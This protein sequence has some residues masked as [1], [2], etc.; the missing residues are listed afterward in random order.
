LGAVEANRRTLGP[1]AGADHRAIE[2]QSDATQV[3]L[4]QAIQDELSA[5]L[6]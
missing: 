5:Q 3:Q 2:V 4:G 6:P 1:V